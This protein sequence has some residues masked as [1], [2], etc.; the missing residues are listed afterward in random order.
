MKLNK[1]W[2]GYVM[3]CLPATGPWHSGD[4][5]KEMDRTSIRDY[6]VRHKEH[7]KEKVLDYGC[8]KFSR[9]EDLRYRDIV[10]AVGAEYFPY[11]PFNAIDWTKAEEIQKIVA[12][13]NNFF[14]CILSIQMLMETESPQLALLE[15]Y[16]LL[17][18]GGHVIL[19]YTTCWREADSNDK[20]RWTASGMETLVKRNTDF[21]ILDH[22]TRAKAS[23]QNFNFILGGGILLRKQV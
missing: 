23:I 15:M 21:E 12:T 11:D 8:G 4:P 3:S 19:T 17:K 13:E 5:M 10:L 16:R 14:S 2:A 20:W 9:L 7:I 22:V 6:I 1:P 18:P